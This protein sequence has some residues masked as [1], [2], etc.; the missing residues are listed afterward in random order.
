MQDICKICSSL[1]LDPKR[2]L[3]Y[4]CRYLDDKSEELED[5]WAKIEIEEIK[6]KEN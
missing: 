5:Y 3:C 2:E 6:L 1:K 4:N